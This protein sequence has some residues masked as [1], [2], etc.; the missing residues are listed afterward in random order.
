[1]PCRT[2]ISVADPER[3]YANPDPSCSLTLKRI[4]LRTETPP[5]KIFDLFF[6]LMILVEF[7]EINIG[8]S[9]APKRCGSGSTRQIAKVFGVSS[10][11]YIKMS[12]L[13]R[14]NHTN[15]QHNLF[16][17]FILMIFRKCDVYRLNDFKTF[18]YVHF[19]SVLR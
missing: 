5:Q 6:L 9:N 13:P 3:F 17:L 4:R 11:L 19:W 14:S 1:M 2:R 8:F 7:S 18:K 16:S 10:I 15:T 12:F